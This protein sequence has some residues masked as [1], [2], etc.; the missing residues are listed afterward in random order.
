MKVSKPSFSGERA[1][2]ENTDLYKISCAR[3]EF[4]KKYVKPNFKILDYACGN[5][6]G[7]QIIQNPINK[8]R[9]FGIDISHQ[10]IAGAVQKYSNQNNEFILIDGYEKVQK[11]K[12]RINLVL[13]FETIEHIKY[14]DKY[15][16]NIKFYVKNK[17]TIVLSTP[18]NYKRIH[19]PNNKFHVKEYHIEDIYQ[20]LKI[21]F[22]NKKIHTYGQIKSG[23]KSNQSN[24]NRWT[25]RIFYK[26]I[27]NIIYTIDYKY[28]KILRRINQTDIYKFFGRKQWLSSSPIPYKIK[29]E[30]SYMHPQ[31]SIFVISDK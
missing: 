16:E 6:Y 13:A 7:A 21:A 17:S 18:N 31:I 25:I 23:I 14:I 12:N 8:S 4:A 19:P 22:P 10:A 9:Y 30:P 3:Y 1:V 28:L 27:L 26:L 5:G 2:E 11:L 15:I 29:L 24:F 20:I